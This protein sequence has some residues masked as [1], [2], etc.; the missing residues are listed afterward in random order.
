MITTKRSSPYSVSS[1][2]N[3]NTAYLFYG[4]SSLLADQIGNGPS[5]IVANL[6][7]NFPKRYQ[8]VRKTD[9]SVSIV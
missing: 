2:L 7:V 4:P 1:V 3:T 6:S 5:A 9:S 8:R